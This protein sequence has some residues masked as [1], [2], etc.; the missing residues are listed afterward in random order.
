MSLD[1]L[2]INQRSFYDLPNS[3]FWGWL[4]TESQP[5]N[6]EFRNNPENFHPCT[7]SDIYS[8]TLVLLNQNVSFF[9]NTV[10]LDQLASSDE[11][12]CSGPTMAYTLIENT[13]L[14]LGSAVAQW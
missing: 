3:A 13:S 1:R 7:D 5:Q 2:K 14:Q 4:S 6:P 8:L 9:D 12:I 11:T 10:D